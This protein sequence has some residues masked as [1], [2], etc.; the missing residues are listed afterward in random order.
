MDIPASEKAVNISAW[1]Y[2]FLFYLRVMTKKSRKQLL[3]AAE[4]K[5]LAEKSIGGFGPRYYEAISLFEYGAEEAVKAIE[6]K[7]Y[8]SK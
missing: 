5:K 1:I 2:R 6:K 8:E 4:I 3:T 7:L